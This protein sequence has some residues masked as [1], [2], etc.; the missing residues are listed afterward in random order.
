MGKES[1]TIA[2]VSNTNHNFA[3]PRATLTLDWLVTNVWVPTDSLGFSNSLY[4]D[5]Q[6]SLRTIMLI[7]MIT[8]YKGYML[9]PA[10]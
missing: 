9:E 8:A 5:S 4:N 1:H 3:G 10:K 2:L 6:N 7:A